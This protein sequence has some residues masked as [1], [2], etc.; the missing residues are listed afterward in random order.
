MFSELN[1]EEIVKIE[2]A[3]REAAQKFPAAEVE[4]PA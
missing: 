4:L 1:D 3:I 2:T